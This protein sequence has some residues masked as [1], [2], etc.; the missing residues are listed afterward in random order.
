MSRKEATGL[1]VQN[2]EQGRYYCE[3]IK[4]KKQ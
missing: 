1:F 4:K 3:K 2:E